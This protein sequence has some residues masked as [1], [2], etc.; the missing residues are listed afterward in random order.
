MQKLFFIVFLLMSSAA[1]ADN[2]DLVRRLD[3]LS[4]LAQSMPLSPQKRA[5]AERHIEA[6]ETILSDNGGGGG[7]RR[8]HESCLQISAIRLMTSDSTD[9]SEIRQLENL[10]CSS[11]EVPPGHIFYPNGSYAFVG[12]GYSDS[13]SWKYPNGKFA[14]VK[15]NYSDAGTVYYPNGKHALVAGNYSDAGSWK[16]PDGSYAFVAGNYS[17]AGTYYYPNKK[18][19]YVDGNY[20]DKGSWKYPNGKFAFVGGNYSDRDTWYYP[21]GTIFKVDP[22][23]TI[24]NLVDMVEAHSGQ[25]FYMDRQLMRRLSTTPKTILVLQWINSVIQ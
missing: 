14:I 3:Q 21:T 10:I 19:A 15:G 23:F 18:H 24:E 17:D 13:G 6:L 7:N 12:P 2:E 20:S 5:Q 4:Q 9:Q 22:N 11:P 16:Y 8:T 25:T 1:H